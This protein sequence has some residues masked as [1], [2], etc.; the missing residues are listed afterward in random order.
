MGEEKSLEL[1][2][3]LEEYFGRAS[4]FQ[5]AVFS[6]IDF[7]KKVY[8]VANPRKGIIAR[9]QEDPKNGGI[10]YKELIAECCP[11]RV[12]VFEDPLGGVRK[13]EIRFGGLLEKVIGPADFETIVQRLKSEAV[14]KHKRLIE[15]ALS[16]LV[17]A[18]IRNGKAEIRRELEKPGFYYI[19][20]IIKAVKWEAE[21]FSRDD[22]KASLLLL[23]ELREEWYSHLAERFTTIVKWGIIA[24]F[25]YAI[26]QIRG[27]YGIHF[28]W[29]L[30]HG[31]ASTGKSTL[32]KIIRAIWNLPP[33]EKGGS[34]ID[35]VPRF[36]KVVSE[37][38]F[39]VLINEVADVLSKDSLRE[40]LKSSIETTFAR[41]RYV[42]G[43]YVEEPALAPMIFT[44]NKT[45]PA[46]DALLRRFVA[47][48]FSLS[49]RVSEEKAK[50]F[51]I[52]VLPKICD[53]RFLGFYVFKRI[54]ENPEL[55]KE[56]W[57][58]LSTLLLRDAFEYVGFEAP[59]WVEEEHRGRES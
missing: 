28:P 51:E 10:V 18:F 37:S 47:I 24:P 40:V 25:S 9:A 19:G 29:L 13:F 5:D 30:L 14:V 11:I 50:R 7:S 38:T 15:D 44:T 49:D 3:R 34:H 8:Y 17:T 41:G 2:R 48:L 26:K 46:D 22:L 53:L 21:D 54:S 27:T 1:I 33:E 6:L 43:V 32:G 16:S 59:E 42:Q 4:P 36:G 31:S 52:E 35:T 39:P 58:P 55:L 20:G 57:L 56:G 23:R 45:Y 12:T